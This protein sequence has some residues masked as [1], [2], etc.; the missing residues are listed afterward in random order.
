MF[1]FLQ[2]NISCIYFYF[3]H[4][5]KQVESANEVAAIETLLISDQLFR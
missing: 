3:L 2:I 1:Y 4:R 5:V